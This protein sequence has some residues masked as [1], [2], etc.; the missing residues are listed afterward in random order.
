MINRIELLTDDELR[1]ICRRISGKTL[2]DLYQK[3]GNTFNKLKRGFRPGSLSDDETYNFACSNRNT[4]FIADFLDFVVDR[5]LQEICEAKEE[6]IKDGMAENV[7]IIETLANSYFDER[8]DLYFKMLEMDPPIGDEELL[9]HVVKVE[10]ERNHLSSVASDNV[11]VDALVEQLRNTYESEAQ[12]KQEEH[13]RALE[14]AKEELDKAQST[15]EQYRIKLDGAESSKA[16]MEDELKTYREMAAHVDVEEEMKPTPG[17]HYASLCVAY[18]DDFGRNR[19]LRVADIKEGEFSDKLSESA[20]E[21]T[22]LYS[23]DGPANDG[24]I[25]VWDWRVVPNRSDPTKDFIESSY[26]ESIKPIEVI[27]LGE[28]NSIDAIIEVLRK[29]FSVDLHAERILFSFSNGGKYEGVYCDS[30]TLDYKSGIATLKDEVLKLPVYKVLKIDTLLLEN[31]VL[32]NVN[33]LVRANLGMPQRL[34]RVKAPMDIV[35]NCIISKTTWAASQQKG[36]VRSEYQQIRA[37][38]MELQTTDLYEDISRKCDCSLDEAIEYVTAFMSRADKVVIGDTV[39]NDVMVQIIENDPDAY[40]NCMSALRT[41]W[42]QE[43]A[44]TITEAHAA[45]EAI[46][47]D[48]ASY[49]QSV[50]KKTQELLD[51]QTKI[52]DASQEL[53]RQ[54][55]MAEEVESLVLQKI[56]HAKNYAADFIANSVFAQAVSIAPTNNSTTKMVSEESRSLFTAHKTIDSE[57]PDVNE[58][59]DQLL[60]TVQFELCEAG[61]A[62]EYTVGLA[63]MLYGAYVRRIPVLLA[64]PNGHEIAD[65]FAA[66]MDAKTAAVFTCAGHEYTNLDICESSE[67]E[68]VV[69]ENPLQ[70]QWENDVI[71]LISKREK[72]FIMTQPFADDLVVEPRGLFNYCLPVLTELFVSQLPSRN[73]TGG[74]MSEAFVHYVPAAI[75]EKYGKILDELNITSLTRDNVQALI[76]DIGKLSG[77]D[78]AD[79]ILQLLL[80]P[81]AY[82]VG[83]QHTLIDK[84]D[85]ME[86]KPTTRTIARLKHLAGEEE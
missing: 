9:R 22:R 55:N 68:I 44:S 57:E 56:E 31:A 76:T 10:S 7:A 71:R 33:V 8:P 53:D 6:A 63:S 85:V 51:I 43:N 48:E 32:E 78:E 52:S 13:E 34:V 64:G 49:R 59:Y 82:A 83:E 80:Y 54:K 50:E 65:A 20:P 18:R 17:F 15:V 69:I 81:L 3:N 70:A 37:F 39:E 24:D 2:R 61:V 84:I 12:G 73:Y 27:A 41:T 58:T 40:A 16:A 67:E 35:R 25:G 75:S 46:K 4:P 29:G 5:W 36:F 77:R 26:N 11:D 66:A 72:F 21:Y 86:S 47:K 79:D 1:Y 42:E 45:L 74:K 30:K 19:L 62:E 60:Q 14:A 38:L 23:H 28:C